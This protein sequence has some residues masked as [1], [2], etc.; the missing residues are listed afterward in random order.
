MK[1][2]QALQELGNPD[3]LVVAVSGGPDSVALLRALLPYQ[4]RLVVA[5]LNHRLRGEE[6]DADEDFVR[7]LAQS[8][9]GVEICVERIEVAAK[10]AAAGDNLEAAARTIRYQ[11]LAEVA[12]AHQL[13]AVATGHTAD[14]QAETVLHRLLRGTGLKGLR[15]IAA[16]RPLAPGIVLLRPLLNV[17]RAEVLEYLRTIGQPFREDRTNRDPRFT[18]TRLRHELLPLLREHYN[19]AVDEILSRLAQQAE[20][21]FELVDAQA[22]QLLMNAERP[23]AGRWI[24]LD[25]QTLAAAPPYLVREAFRCLWQR[26]AWPEQAM[27]FAD[28][29]RLAELAAGTSSGIDL[30]GGLRAE[31]RE[32]VVRVGP[33]S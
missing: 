12:R 30:P 9:P 2:A 15:G 19:P 22:R 23:Q 6:S 29:Q 28:W 21:L 7:S 17:T 14:D 31:A 10:A 3:G 18:R 32:H 13:P 1:V 24:I 26:E 20:E 4:G 11:W 8:H 27:G 16:T 5:H 25:R 33:V